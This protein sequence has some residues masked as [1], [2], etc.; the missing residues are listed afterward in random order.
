[1][2]II[3]H[4][5]TNQIGGCITEITSDSGTK[6]LID[7]GANLPDSQGIKKPEIE[8]EGLTKGEPS[9]DAIFITHYHGD[10][11]G[12]YNK[13]FSKI[14]IFIGEISKGIFSLVQT[15]LHKANIV[16]EDEL[17]IIA[18]FNT[19]TI[20][21]KISI[22]DIK[23]T[24]IAVDHSAFDSYMFLI[25]A[26]GKKILHTGDFRTH[27]QRGKAVLE[28]IK[29][30]VGKVD[31]LICEGTTL[32]RNNDKLLT[33]FQLQ[34]KAEQLF[35][36]NKYNFVLC[37]STN[38]DRIAALHKAAI[39]THKMFICDKYQGEILEYVNKNSRSKLY[40]FNNSQDTKVYY[41]A[42][43]MLEKMKKYGFVMLVRANDKFKPIMDIF[44]NSTFIYSQ[45]LGYL[46]GENEDYKR[47]QNFVPKD[48]IYLHTSGHATPE[49]IKK[50][51]EITNPNVV[52]PIHTE[53]K[54]KIKELTNK[55]IILEDDEEFIVK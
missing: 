38:I 48:Y 36:E 3:I 24:P 17:K 34:Q 25:E 26:D 27:G 6:I 32:T 52:I 5:G 14:P 12:L 51:I 11:I 50:V 44:D 55:A 43:N 54:E 21:E 7:I 35:K 39:N 16:T 40:K 18:N 37:S 13:V 23:V 22:N 20:R 4:R 15:R 53:E 1:M 10:H 8:L 19:F 9:F 47:I 46:K 42:P 2:K 28:A 45:W 41:Y 30:Y 49:A 33:E 29:K 31:C